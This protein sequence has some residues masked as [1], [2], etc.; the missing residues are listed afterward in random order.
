MS[1]WYVRQPTGTVGP[2]SADAVRAAVEAGLV[3][4]GDLVKT[5]YDADW[6]RVEVSM[7]GAWLPVK[8]PPRPLLAW[9][10]GLVTLAFGGFLVWG[11]V[12]GL[13][14]FGSPTLTAWVVGIVGFL[15]LFVAGLRS[16]G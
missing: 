6:Q 2:V 12:G 14:Y 1:S 10:P 5:D 9:F 15:V 3:R 8:V 4:R 13:M 11:V 16:G 7:F